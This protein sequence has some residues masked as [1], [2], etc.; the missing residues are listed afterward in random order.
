M[1]LVWA[2]ELEKWLPSIRPSRIHVIESKADRLQ[3][4]RHASECCPDSSLILSILLPWIAA[5]ALTPHGSAGYGPGLI[6]VP[7]LDSAAGLINL[8]QRTCCTLP[9][10]S[11][12]ECFNV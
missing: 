8:F 4:C 9:V 12:L 7:S 11:Q 2:E 5:L 3:V 6:R 10:V 1:R